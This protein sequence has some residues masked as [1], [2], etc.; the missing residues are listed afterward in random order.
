MVWRVGA[1]T[2]HTH[3][4]VACGGGHDQ[5]CEKEEI[6][7]ITF[8]YNRTSNQLA[9]APLLHVLVLVLVHGAV[10]GLVLVHG[11]VGRAEQF[12]LIHLFLLG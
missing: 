2:M 8:Y 5:A 9:L 12:F 1:D 11:G 4:G 6:F 3:H 10:G 7:F